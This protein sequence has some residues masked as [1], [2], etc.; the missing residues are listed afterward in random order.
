MKP[1]Y[2]TTQE[3]GYTVV[4]ATAFGLTVATEKV[5]GLTKTAETEA[6]KRCK[7]RVKYNISQARA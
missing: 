3:N 2:Q 6:M 5:P 1:T 7:A 4:R